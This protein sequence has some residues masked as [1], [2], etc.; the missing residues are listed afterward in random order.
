MNWEEAR[1]LC[2]QYDDEYLKGTDGWL[3]ALQVFVK[4]DPKF[5]TTKSSLN[6]E[7]DI[8]YVADH[9]ES[10][11]AEDIR[12]LHANGFHLNA[13]GNCWAMFT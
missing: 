3:K 10:M 5:G 4:Y 11:T 8:L 12:Y 1:E 9:D 6:A 13:D 2:E 7:H